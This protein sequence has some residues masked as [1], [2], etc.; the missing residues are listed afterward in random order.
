MIAI[1]AV[2]LRGGACVQLVG[3]D[4]TAERV[5]LDDAV[6][7][8]RTWAD[9]GFSRLHLVDLDAALGAGNN[10]ALVR[11]VLGATE[12]PTQVGGGAR[13]D[14]A[15]SGLLAD[16]AAAVVVGTR[17]I[18]DPAWLTALAGRHVDRVIV[19][20]D[21]RERQVVVRGWAERL[22]LDITDA[23]ARLDGLPLAGILVTAVHREGQLAGPDLQ[24]LESVCTATAAP[25]YGA[26]GVAS[27]DDLQRLA[28]CGVRG[29]VIGMALYTG[30]LDPQ[31]VAQTYGRDSA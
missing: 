14:D 1:P 10:R 16:G 2:D 3:G 21:T 11:R 27:L 13:D 30:A 8:A 24:L 9:M 31:V 23:V 19:A 26:G 20:V 18:Q 6:G 22:P 5:R 17:A 29:A 28:D 15:V 4:P 25:V 7:A 12:L